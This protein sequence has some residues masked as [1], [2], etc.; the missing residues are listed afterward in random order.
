MQQ[1]PRNADQVQPEPAELIVP[2]TDSPR[3]CHASTLCS[4][5]DGALLA[6]W[7]SG[8]KEGATD[9][10]IW[11]SRRESGGWSAPVEA[12]RHPGIPCWNPVLHTEDD[13]ILCFY[14]IGRSPRNWNTM[15]VISEDRGTSWSSP[16]E[17]VAG[18]Q[19]PRGPVKNKLLVRD[20]GVWLAPASIEEDDR[21]D[22]F[23][24]ISTDR[25]ASW[26][27]SRPVPIDHT[28]FAGKGVIQP[29]LWQTADR[30]IHMLL[31]STSGHICRSD[32]VDG[33]ESW[34]PV[35]ETRLPNNNSGIDLARGKNGVLALAYNPISGDWAPRSTLAI[36]RSFDDG[37]SFDPPWIIEQ[38]DPDSPPP[39]AARVEYSYPA[40]IATET[41]FALT[42]TWN[43]ASIAYRSFS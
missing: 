43:R 29:T 11:S 34:S 2:P 30:S 4:L 42:Y 14:K 18:A 20:D 15:V 10:G 8:T 41:G 35:S 31:R 27:K 22:A 38:T 19:V 36:A 24:D 32:S 33:G 23:V 12:A 16:R 5:A 39:Q 21:W 7:F 37:A 1:E 25:G 13:T 6:A 17:L 9:V 28:G 3:E 26:R 40:I